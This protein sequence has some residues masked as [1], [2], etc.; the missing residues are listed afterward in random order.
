MARWY[1]LDDDPAPAAENM[2]KDEL[3][4]DRASLGEA[5][6]VLRLYRF[7]PSAVTIGCHQDAERILDVEALRADGVEWVRRI[8]GGRALLHEGELTYCLVAPTGSLATGAGLEGTYLTISQALRDALRSVGVE[9]EISRG[10]DHASP[11][12]VAPPCLCSA[13]RHE[14]TARGRKIAGSAQRRRASA[15]LQHGSILLSPGSVRIARYVRGAWG[16]FERRVTSVSEEL[17]AAVDATTLRSALAR[18]FSER[19]DVEWEA[20]SLSRG[21]EAEVRRRAAEKRRDAAASVAEEVSS[22]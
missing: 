19:F 5:A 14:L 11:T 1:L 7:E 6:P 22:P 2:A 18:S 3:L 13:S 4:F 20:L 9:A 15:L 21:E 16:P 8:T 12:G 10:R 17:G